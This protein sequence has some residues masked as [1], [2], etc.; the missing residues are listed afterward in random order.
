MLPLALGLGLLGLLPVAQIASATHARPR[1]A[2]PLRVSLVIAYKEC[3]SPNRMHGEP[4]ASGSCNPPVQS[5]S[6][7]TVGT[8]DA[9]GATANSRGFLQLEVKPA[10][11]DN[12]ILSG[13]I[14]D[15][16]CQSA[17]TTTCG[18]ANAAGG[19]DYTGELQAITTIR[20]TDHYNG[21]IGS[22][23]GTDPATVVDVP[24]P[25]N[26]FC[27][28]TADTSIGGECNVNTYCPLPAPQGCGP[29]D[30]DRSL[31]EVRQIQVFDG[32]PD[33]A[34]ATQDN[35]LFA[36]QGLFIP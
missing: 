12:V 20:I 18:S 22:G 11:F 16:R 21:P 4:L 34:V 13:T 9:N 35:T 19:P 27:V 3:T 5:S 26:L 14:T 32:G 15:V 6:F 25:I 1:G 2:T 30:G 10:T 36:V 33:G 31:V 23:G 8:L 17:A 28:G 7:L 24:Q 29:R